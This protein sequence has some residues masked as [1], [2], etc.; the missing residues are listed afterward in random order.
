MCQEAW[1]RQRSLAEMVAAWQERVERAVAKV[2]N[3]RRERESLPPLAGS[4]RLLIPEG[5]VFRLLNLRAWVL[6]YHV[7]LEWLLDLL[8]NVR[9]VKA[10]QSS[11]RRQRRRKKKDG[12]DLISLGV[13]AKS[14]MSEKTRAY[15]E[16]AVAREFPC[17]E[18]EKMLASLREQVKSM[19]S[20]R[21]SSSD[22][23]DFARLYRSAVE[24]RRAAVP[25]DAKE[26]RSYRRP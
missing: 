8:L 21:K 16:E 17:G 18:N 26:R 13:S 1:E 9:F 5:Q 3:Q 11:L 7:T 22:P 12:D 2:E 23:D 10:R 6:R 19:P 14:L 20:A 15:V 4:P 24:K 25:L